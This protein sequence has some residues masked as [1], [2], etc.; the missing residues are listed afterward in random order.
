MMPT[1]YG[2]PPECGEY[3]G[4]PECG[5]YQVVPPVD[6]DTP[7]A[8]PT[9]TGETDDALTHFVGEVDYSPFAC[10]AVVVASESADS[11]TTDYSM[12]NASPMM[13]DYGRA[14]AAIDDDSKKSPRVPPTNTP[15]SADQHHVQHDTQPNTNSNI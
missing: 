6:V 14:F 4:P 3:R 5:E 13:T 10:S 7:T 11:T 12:Y 1:E 9:S 8:I 2:G 15:H